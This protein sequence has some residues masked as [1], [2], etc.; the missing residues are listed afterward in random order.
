MALAS[1][2]EN[3]RACA[4]CEGDHDA[5]RFMPFRFP[6]ITPTGGSGEVVYEWWALCPTTGEPILMR[7]E[8]S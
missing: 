1:R 3:V 4:R 2:T 5:V 7:M 6:V 8:A